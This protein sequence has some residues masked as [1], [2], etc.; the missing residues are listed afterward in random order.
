MSTTKEPTLFEG[1]PLRHAEFA[2]ELNQAFM[3]D[4]VDRPELHH[5]RQVLLINQKYTTGALAT[6]R[7]HM[8]KGET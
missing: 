5:L 7:E 6:L 2:L 1:R 8:A 3:L 4:L